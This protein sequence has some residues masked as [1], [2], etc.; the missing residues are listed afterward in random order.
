MSELY[1]KEQIRSAAQHELVQMMNHLKKFHAM[2]NIDE[3]RKIDELLDLAEK[4]LKS[5]QK[6]YLTKNHE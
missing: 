1:T 2:A 4:C 5:Y 3:A 6:N